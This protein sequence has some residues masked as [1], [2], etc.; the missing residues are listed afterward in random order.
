MKINGFERK[1]YA[2]DVNVQGGSATVRGPDGKLYTYTLEYSYAKDGSIKSVIKGTDT[3]GN[4]IALRDSEKPTW[5]VSGIDPVTG[6]KIT[7]IREGDNLAKLDANGNYIPFDGFHEPEDN[8]GFIVN[9]QTGK[10]V[11]INSD[12]TL[13]YYSGT[14][15]GDPNRTVFSGGSLKVDR[16]YEDRDKAQGIYNDLKKNIMTSLKQQAQVSKLWH[17]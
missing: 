13:D 14:F 10:R 12:G 16:W 17:S 7:I 11:Y 2:W 6:K 4:T 1:K 15:M 9:P 5:S 3:N 8:K